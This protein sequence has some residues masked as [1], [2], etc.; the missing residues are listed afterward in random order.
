MCWESDWSVKLDMN[1][2]VRLLVTYFF[3]LF[4]VHKFI[5]KQYGMGILYLL[6]FGLCGLG[7][8]YDVVKAF[9]AL[10]QKAKPKSNSN[11]N[12]KEYKEV[13]H[14]YR[15]PKINP[16]VYVSNNMQLQNLLRIINDSQ[17]FILGSQNIDTILSRFNDLEENLERL[18][19]TKSYGLVIEPI[20]YKQYYIDRKDEIIQMRLLSI[21]E[22]QLERSLDLKTEKGRINRI[23]KM[24]SS[25]ENNQNLSKYHNYLQKLKKEGINHKI[26]IKTVKS[27]KINDSTNYLVNISGNKRNYRFMTLDEIVF[28]KTLYKKLLENGIDNLSLN[29]IGGNVLNYKIGRSQIGRLSLSG[30]QHEMQFISSEKVICQNCFSA[31]EAIKHIDEWINYSLGIIGYNLY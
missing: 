4:G 19:F 5:D 27:L 17:Y 1:K 23:N 21:F 20:D 10:F 13:T 6:T 16:S 22:G 30:N 8:I 24:F 2:W 18:D 25:L 11:V 9:I 15:E 3:G 14:T 7:W 29:C 26:S 28:T 31:D 12:T